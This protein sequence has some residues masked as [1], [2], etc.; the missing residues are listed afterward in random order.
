MANI[1]LT[2]FAGIV[3]LIAATSLVGIGVALAD[4]DNNGSDGER[5]ASHHKGDKDRGGRH[6]GKM[7]GGNYE[8]RFATLDADGDGSVTIEEFE[9]AVRKPF[10]EADTNGD[11][12]LSREELAAML[13]EK[14]SN[15]MEKM[16]DRMMSRDENDDGMLSAEELAGKRSP[17]KMFEH[18]DDN[19]DGMLTLEEMQ[20]R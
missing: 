7:H 2:K 20:H 6:H 12:M 18:M 13:A 19:D 5:Y 14:Q 17:S 4:S 9:A 3:A 10:E 16:L 15:R 1:S 8:E 11:G